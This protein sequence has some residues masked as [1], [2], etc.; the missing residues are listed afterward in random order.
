[1]TFLLINHFVYRPF[2]K[3][4]HRNYKYCYYF[5]TGKISGFLWPF[6]DMNYFYERHNM[7]HNSIIL[8][9]IIIIQLL[10]IAN[11]NN[12]SANNVSHCT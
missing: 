10:P 9:Y 4:F 2:Y 3:M 7:I 12:V 6:F 11:T 1:M 8:E 5:R